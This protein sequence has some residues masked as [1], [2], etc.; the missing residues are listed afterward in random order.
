MSYGQ[1][2]AENWIF[3]SESG[4]DFSTDPPTVIASSPM[5]FSLGSSCLSDANGDLLLYTEGQTIWNGSGQILSNGESIGGSVMCSQPALIVPDPS[6]SKSYYVFAVDEYLDFMGSDNT[7]FSYSRVS[8]DGY[9][10]VVEKDVLLLAETPQYVTAVKH[11]NGIDYW[12]LAHERGS[13]RFF[14][15]PVTSD[16]GLHAENPKI[17]SKGAQH[18]GQTSNQGSLKFSPDGS[19]IASAQMDGT[20]ELFSF[21][22]ST[23]EIALIDS[24]SLERAYSVEFDADSKFLYAATSHDWGAV[25]SSDIYQYD[26]SRSNPLDPAS[27]YLVSSIP[28]DTVYATLQLAPN[29]R[30]YC[31]KY[32]HI[33]NK[34]QYVSVIHNPSRPGSA[35]NFNNIDGIP[36][37]GLDLGSQKLLGGLPNFVTSYLDMPFFIYDSICYKNTVT[38]DIVNK[39]NNGTI[40]WNF[41]DPDSDNNSSSDPSPLHIFSAP[42]TYS[43]SVTVSYGGVDYNYTEDVVV[44]PLP[45]IDFG[46]DTIYVFPGAIAPLEV[47]EGYASYVWQDG[48][49]NNIYLAAEQ[50]DYT[51][52][53]TDALGCWD[54]KTVTILPANI[55]FPNAFTPN[56]D[57]RNDIFGPIGAE[58]GLYNIRMFIYNRMGQLMYESPVLEELGDAVGDFG[59]DGTKAGTMQPAGTYVWI[60]KFDVEKEKD[61]FSTEQYSG[62]VTLLR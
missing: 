62:S 35:C 54:R 10:S 51:V 46:S 56:N 39:H 3:A 43:V 61:V 33:T 25:L 47:A 22:N 30:I 44:N 42:G 49:T 36:D 17:F 45:E 19:Y 11:A 16:Q 8:F 53:V 41:G 32:S 29:R 60:V 13:N 40:S 24:E 59:W 55:Y 50:G 18:L 7:C 23:G 48:S 5:T 9:G 52:T 20:I 34:G 2:E 28:R 15:Y 37:K 14:V 1:N 27:S 6:R 12:V 26:L 58:N 4:L 38:F 57:G 21:D 31:A